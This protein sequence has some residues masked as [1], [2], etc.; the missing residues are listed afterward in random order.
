[1]ASLF[2]I[3]L[4]LSTV[5]A[6]PSHD[7]VKR[8]VK[9]TPTPIEKIPYQVALVVDN[10]PICGGSII[11][12]DIILTA[13]HCCCSYLPNDT[14]I[15]AGMYNKEDMPN[16]KGIRVKDVK[17][18]EL[19]NYT[20]EST[21]DDIALIVLEENLSFNRTINKIDLVEEDYEIPVNATVSGW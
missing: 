12:E 2:L 4:I 8:V 14:L 18:H 17:I 15:Y 21:P 16:L 19:Y 5:S 3:V 20:G 9:G 7:R 11:R 10:F 13:A 1:M 6:L